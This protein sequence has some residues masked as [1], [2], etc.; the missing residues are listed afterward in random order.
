MPGDIGLP[1][2]IGPTGFAGDRGYPGPSVSLVLSFIQFRSLLHVYKTKNG[3]IN[4]RSVVVV[5]MI[6][7]FID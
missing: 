2:G 5:K 3:L 4:T 7:L 6:R 1:G